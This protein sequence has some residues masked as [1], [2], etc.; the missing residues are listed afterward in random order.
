MVGL[1]LGVT[2]CKPADKSSEVNPTVNDPD[3]EINVT[4]EAS[5]T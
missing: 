4:P 5:E 1:V 3:L 2:A